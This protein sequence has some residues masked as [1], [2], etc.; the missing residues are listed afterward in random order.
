M[1][2]VTGGCLC[3]QVRYT[4]TAEPTRSGLCHCKDCQ[5]H[6]G[7][8]FE[9]FMSFPTSA[10]SIQGTLKTFDRPGGSGQILHRRFCPHCGSG[11]FSQSAA[12]PGSM[13][14]LVGTLDDATVFAPTMEVFCDHAQ[15]WMLD[16]SQ[17]PRFARM[18]P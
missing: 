7:S 1:A 8:A 18:P 14:V 3:G 6:T 11:V 2:N 17:R 13:A 5:R 9:P 15:L 16:G 10:V 12:R 4:I